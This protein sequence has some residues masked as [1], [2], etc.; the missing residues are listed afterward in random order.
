ASA[1]AWASDNVLINVATGAVTLPEEAREAVI[2][3]AT[4]TNGTGSVDVAFEVSVGARRLTTDLFI[5]EYIEGSSNNKALEIY[6]GTGEA[7]DLTGYS[8]VLYSNGSATAS[9]TY[10]LTG[11]L[12]DGEVFVLA[13]SGANAAI[14]AIADATQGYPSVPNF[15]GD[16]AVALLKGEVVIDVIGV[17][18]VDPGS[19][20]PVGTGATNEYTL[21]RSDMVLSPNATFTASEWVVYPQDTVD[22]LGSHV[23]N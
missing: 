15:N 19:N 2:L 7:V 10:I 16:D 18:G 8:L 1:I 17:I 13:N 22:Y 20:W 12:N 5:S 4:V 6:N 9:Q 23:Q 21:V 14:L 3:T 11:T